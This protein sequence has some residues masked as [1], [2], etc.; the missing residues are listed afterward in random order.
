LEDGSLHLGTRS[1]AL[2]KGVYLWFGL[3]VGVDHWVW[4]YD[5]FGS[6]MVL[7]FYSNVLRN[8]QENGVS[9]VDLFFLFKVWKSSSPFKDRMP[10]RHNLLFWHIISHLADTMC[11]SF[12]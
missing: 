5:S 11:P 3:L 9:Y 1:L 2:A 6:Y 8:S 7:S 12:Y 4:D 10:T